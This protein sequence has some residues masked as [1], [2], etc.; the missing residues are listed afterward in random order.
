MDEQSYN[1]IVPVKVGNHRASARSGHGTHWREVEQAD[2]SAEGNIA[3]A[4]NQRLHPDSVEHPPRPVQNPVH[5]YNPGVHTINAPL[6]FP[7]D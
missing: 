6:R 2:G 5:S 3:E 1:P 7:N 4:R